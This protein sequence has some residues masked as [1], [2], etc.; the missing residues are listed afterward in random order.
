[1]GGGLEEIP[2]TSS[3]FCTTSGVGMMLAESKPRKIPGFFD[4]GILRLPHISTWCGKDL[5][6]SLGPLG[7]LTAQFC[8]RFSDG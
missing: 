5:S 6:G 8:V 2:V 1:V 4:R 7:S 3:S